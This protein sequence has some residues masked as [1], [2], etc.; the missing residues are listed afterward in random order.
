[1]GYDGWLLCRSRVLP[2]LGGQSVW[3]KASEVEL[4]GRREE[5]ERDN[6]TAIVVIK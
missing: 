1:M 6:A 2:S 3:W 4:E 5:E